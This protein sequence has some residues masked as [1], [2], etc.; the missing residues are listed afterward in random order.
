[1]LAAFTAGTSAFCSTIL[2]E[3]KITL[4]AGATLLFFT[5][6]VTDSSNPQGEQFGH[7]QLKQTL[8]ALAGRSGQETCNLLLETLKRY[9]ADA[10]Q[11]DD[12][13]MVAIHSVKRI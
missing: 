1:L 6:G 13:T 5:D 11:S 2:D 7:E 12:I 8:A 10:S 3:Q 9:Q 4:P